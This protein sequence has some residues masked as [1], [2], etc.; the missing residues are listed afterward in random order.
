MRTRSIVH[1]L[2]IWAPF[3]QSYTVIKQIPPQ[4]P[5]YTSFKIRLP[6]R[7]VLY[8]TPQNTTALHNFR[9]VLQPSLQNRSVAHLPKHSRAARFPFCIAKFPAKPLCA[10]PLR[11]LPHSDIPVLYYNLLRRSVLC[12]T[13]DTLSLVQFV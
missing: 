7:T 6:H 8:G 13:P 12:C 10:A 2:Y 5:Q 1:P 4:L 3:H 9:S 11:T